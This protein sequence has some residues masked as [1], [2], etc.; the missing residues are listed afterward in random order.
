MYARFRRLRGEREIYLA[1]HRGWQCDKVL[2]KR[3]D[4]LPDAQ[5]PSHAKARNGDIPQVLGL[6]QRLDGASASKSYGGGEDKPDAHEV[7]ERKENTLNTGGSN[8]RTF[9]RR[10]SSES[11]Q[12]KTQRETGGLPP[13]RKR[14]R[15]AQNRYSCAGTVLCALRELWVHLVWVEPERRYGKLEQTE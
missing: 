1:P 12:Q 14:Q 11:V 4:L 5:P 13:L 3:T 8:N 2:A 7:G 15:G 10:T 9:V 6:R